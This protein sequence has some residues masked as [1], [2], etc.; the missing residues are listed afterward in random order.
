MEHPSSHERRRTAWSSL[1]V[2]GPWDL[3][4]IGGGITGAG[5]LREAARRGLRAALVEQR[6]FAWGTSSRSSKLIHGGLRYLAAGQWAISRDSLR[7]RERL[8]GEAPGLVEPL[9]FL[10]SHYRRSFPG[11][12]SFGALLSVYGLLSG[13]RGHRYFPAREYLLMAPRVREKGLKGGSRYLDA[14]TDDSRMVYRLISE[15]R[16]ERTLALN[17]VRA[18]ELM[19]R[20]GRVFGAVVQDVISGERAE[21]QAAAIVNATGV[22]LDRFREQVGGAKALR[23]LR[24]SHLVFSSWRLPVAQAMGMKHPRDGR[25]VFIFPWEGVSLIGSTDLDHRENLDSEPSITPAEVDYLLQLVNHQ[26]PGLGIGRKDILCTYS[27]VRPIVAGGT[28]EPSKEKRDHKV[29]VEGGLISVGGGKLTTFRLMAL[30]ALRHAAQFLP[31]LR[32]QEGEGRVFSKWEGSALEMGRLTHDDRRRIVGRYGPMADE[33]LSCAREGELSRVQGTHTLWVEIRW[34]ARHEDV[35]HLEDLLM[36][37]TRLGITLP[38]G[39]EACLE[40][41]GT[42]CQE[43]LGWETTQWDQEV[44]AYRSL[45]ENCMSPPKGPS[46]QEL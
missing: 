2:S 25:H 8:L 40:R 20:G 31:V 21:V 9:G 34:A 46:P 3:L 10:F 35:V 15:G 17:Y 5:I 41:I 39:G 33:V 22:W 4:I 26:F 24:G 37:R 19:V 11:R 32:A 42:I 12:W 29:W 43:E 6:D 38:G 7:E 45:W 14:V 36:R 23:P 28:A 30:D 16:S 18:E 44:R 27:G 1:A 13:R